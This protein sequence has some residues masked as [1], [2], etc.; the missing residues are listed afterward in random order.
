M[1]TIGHN[2]SS[3]SQSQSLGGPEQAWR[4]GFEGQQRSANEDDV[5]DRRQQRSTTEIHEDDG[6]RRRV[7]SQRP[8]CSTRRRHDIG[9]R[10]SADP[11]GQSGWSVFGFCALYVGIRPSSRRR[12]CRRRRRRCR[13]HFASAVTVTALIPSPSFPSSSPCRYWPSRVNDVPPH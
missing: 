11:G 10:H 12:R 2:V 8:R 13:R 3:P 7:P 4:C 1:A 9:R 6:R 5:L